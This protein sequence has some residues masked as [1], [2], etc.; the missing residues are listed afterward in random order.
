MDYDYYDNYYTD[1]LMHYGIKGMKWGHRKRYYD[2]NG[3][4]NARGIEKYAQAGYSQDSYNSNKT[5]L[6]K[7]YDK[8]TGAHKYGGAAMYGASSAKANKAR[9]E[10]YVADQK[11]AKEARN[12][13]EAKAARRKKALKVGAAV[14]GTAIA[15]YGVYKVKD[16]TN[17]YMANKEIREWTEKNW[18]NMP[19]QV[20]WNPKLNTATVNR[21][22]INRAPIKRERVGEWW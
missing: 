20:N 1:Y 4:L 12:T 19:K 11:A 21:A 18:T 7:A 8:V 3:N 16:Y 13:P 14:A 15:A 22:T 6:G 5:K 9:A 2:S 10:K 17:R